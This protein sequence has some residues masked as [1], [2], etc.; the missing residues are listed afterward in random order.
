MDNVNEKLIEAK[1][2]DIFTIARKN[3]EKKAS[4]FLDPGQQQIA[5]EIARS[6][7]GMGFYFDGGSE[8]AERRIIVAYPED[9]N[10]EPFK[11]P[12]GALRVIPKDP[13]EHPGHRDY[14]GSILGLGINREKLGDILVGKTGADV[15][16]KQEIMEYI[17]LNLIKVGNA[18]VE[19][20]EIS[21]NPKGLIRK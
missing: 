11:Q 19:V 2:R 20:E 17:G 10:D 7:P 12:L 8:E 6:F 5:E 4:N 9:I 1:I 14:L 18:S 13:D 21:T 15:V 3:R 16:V